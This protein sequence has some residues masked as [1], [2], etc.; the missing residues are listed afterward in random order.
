MNSQEYGFAGS[1]LHKRQALLDKGINP[2]PY[3]FR[4]THRVADLIANQDVHVRAR[5]HVTTYGRVWA[6]RNMGKVVFMDLCDNGSKIQLYLRVP[7][8]PEATQDALELS[9]LG[10]IVGASGQIMRT[11]TGELSM[12]VSILEVL[13]KTTIAVPIGK[14]S[15]D[16][17]H[18]DRIADE[19]SRYRERYLTWMLSP[20]ERQRMVTRSRII[21]LIRMWMEREGFLEVATPTI[22]SIYGGAEARPF[23]TTI[24]ALGGA[25]AY[26]RIS[27]ELYLKRYIAGGFEKVFTIC[28]N[29]R[30]EGID[31]SH[32][33]EFTMM[34]WYEAF[35]DYELQMMRF[36]R[37]VAC[38]CE[39]VHGSTRITFQGQQLDFTPPWRRLTVLDGIREATGLEVG[40]MSTAELL[41][42][43]DDRSVSLDEPRTW[44]GAVL[45]L[46]EQLCEPLL[47]Q[48]TL[49]LDYPVE[50][51]PLTK[52]KRGDS[53]L[54]E[55]FEPYVCGIEIGNAYSEAT[56][57]VDQL[58]RLLAQREV[59]RESEYEQ[60]P[61]DADFI[62]AMGMG[63]PP[64][65][66]VGLG[67]DR[68]IMLL[69]DA[70]SIRDVIPF[71]MF[72]PK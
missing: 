14:E 47:Q 2:Y 63:M 1:H 3:T 50:S 33:P 7:E 72:R 41:Q 34:E 4:L 51:S 37:L 18:Y 38:V 60:H 25:T 49:V 71:P 20:L 26:L 5:T 24:W 11:R 10:D 64:T 40:R 42:L 44:G 36:E 57:P 43:L 13:A 8:L 59:Q 54:V 17:V 6:R 29:F 23:R 12:D 9:D 30:N 58:E 53:R 32:N 48:P 39:Q 28:Q 65:G 16:G 15:Q 45:A 21:S 56:D 35:T 61:I 27:P 55:R 68:L 31:R 70:P 69:T 66:G 46:F 52:I 67:I 22:E 62:R 19:E